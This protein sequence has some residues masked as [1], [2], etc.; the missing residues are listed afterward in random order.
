[1]WTVQSLSTGPSVGTW[2]LVAL[3]R[4][5]VFLLLRPYQFIV[6]TGIGFIRTFWFQALALGR[7]PLLGV[8]WWGCVLAKTCS[9]SVPGIITPSWWAWGVRS[10]LLHGLTPQ[11]PYFCLWADVS[12]LDL[13]SSELWQSWV[14]LTS[15][16]PWRTLQHWFLYMS[17]CLALMVGLK[18]VFPRGGNRLISW[19]GV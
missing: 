6:W 5:Y 12:Q 11:T 19:R 4:W 2:R 16:S 17:C 3:P 14:V 8:N 13:L 9:P 15:G 1:M 18:T 10:I 7:C